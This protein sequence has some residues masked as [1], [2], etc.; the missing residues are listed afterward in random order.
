MRITAGRSLHHLAMGTLLRLGR[1]VLR[2]VVR[3]LL[4]IALEVFKGVPIARLLR[5]PVRALGALVFKVS[6]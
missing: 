4:E 1:I 6:A 2:L 3:Q 5:W